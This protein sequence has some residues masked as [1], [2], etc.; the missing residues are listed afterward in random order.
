MHLAMAGIIYFALAVAVEMLTV[1]F[2]LVQSSP[3]VDAQMALTSK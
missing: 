3:D 2:Y 1:I